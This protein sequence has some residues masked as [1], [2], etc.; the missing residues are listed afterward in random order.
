MSADSRDIETVPDAD[1][2]FSFAAPLLRAEEVAD[3]L[4][5]QPS[6]VYELSRR[7]IDP[8]PSI[9]IGRSKRFDRLAIA[10]WVEAHSNR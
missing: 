8:L 4:A 3:L 2:V 9:S 6:T 1:P 10:Q 7:R 5:V